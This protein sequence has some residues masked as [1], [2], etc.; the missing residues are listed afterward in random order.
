MASEIPDAIHLVH[1]RHA[2]YQA[3]QSVPVP[4]AF[5]VGAVLV[6]PD[7]EVLATG[8]SRELPGNTHAEQCC[9]DKLSA[10]GIPVPEGSIM[11]TTMEP[12]SER[13]SG[14]QPCLYRILE[15]GAIKTVVVGVKEPGTFVKENIAEKKLWDGGVRY[16]KVDGIEEEALRVASRQA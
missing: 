9:L 8:F 14:N 5:C 13:L 11:Y 16:L 1:L 2:L 15:T 12:C 7:G 6:G 3:K 4:T 10:L